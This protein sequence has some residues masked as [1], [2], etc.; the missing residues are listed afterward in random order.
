MTECPSHAADR[1]FA[2]EEAD[3][4][5]A[6]T[7]TAMRNGFTL[8]Q[9]DEC[10]DGSMHCVNCPWLSPFENGDPENHWAVFT[11]RTNL[12]KLDWLMLQLREAGIP[13]R[14]HGLSFHAPA[15][16]V[17]K[18]DEGRAWSILDP[19]DDLPDDDPMFV[20]SAP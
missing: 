4:E 11:R 15:L 6:C 10:D 18:A 13:H 7:G 5:A 9:A 8:E 12:P 14:L 3:A 19:V 1:Y 16:W 20:E 2:S 17:R